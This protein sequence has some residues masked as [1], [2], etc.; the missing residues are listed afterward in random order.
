MESGVEFV[1]AD[2]PQ[3][4]RLTVHIMAAMAEYEAAAI[5]ARTKAALAAAKARGTQLGGHRWNSLR[6]G[7][8]GRAASIQVRQQ[9][10]AQRA[11]D[12]LPTVEILRSEG[13]TS[14]RELAAGLNE[15]GIQTARGGNWSAVQVQRLLA[16]KI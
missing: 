15:R 8:K 16:Q 6:I 5:S 10:A 13:A 2:L 1:A 4:N 12:V 14:L 3:A 9:I 7:T 11:A